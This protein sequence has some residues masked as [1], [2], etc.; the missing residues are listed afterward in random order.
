MA[1]GELLLQQAWA[2]R[3][4]PESKTDWKLE[5]GLL[6]RPTRGS[7][8]MAQPILRAPPG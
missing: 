6:Y 8:Q 2:G 3:S 7:L 5:P 4:E 1:G